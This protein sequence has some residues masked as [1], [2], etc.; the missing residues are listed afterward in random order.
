MMH[1][2]NFGNDKVSCAC[3]GTMMMGTRITK[4]DSYKI[5]NDFTENGGNFLDTSDNYSWWWGKGNS[6][7]DES[8]SILGKW[9]SERKNRSKIFLATKFGA[10]PVHPDK[11][12]DEKGG[13]IWDKANNDYEGASAK[14]VKAAIDGS[15]KRLKTDYI[16][17]YYLH[18]DDRSVPLEE[19]LSAL[20]DI[21]KEGKVRYIGCSNMRT[22]R[23]S[24]A[25]KISREKGYPLF[26]AIEEE[27]SYIR[28]NMEADRGITTH[29]DDELFDY[30]KSNPDMK[31]IAYSPV[32]KGIFASK[33]KR[34]KYY[35]WPNFNNG[36]SVER[37]KLIDRMSKE[38]GI[39]GSQLVLAWILHKRPEIIP[40]LGF[41][42]FSQ[43][44]E[45]LEAA[46]VKLSAEQ[47]DVLNKGK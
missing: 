21:V 31:L 24:I 9:M 11:I 29:A 47:M 43:Y 32:L 18:V 44:K 20:A 34:E 22:W 40:I 8:E 27:Y 7:G 4:D 6:A 41:S 15:L 3:L 19:T 17:L 45:N 36:E 13:I 30:L 33:E 12:R 39:T 10:R 5:L 37:I 26:S 14:A 23:L 35:D 28:P 1:K 2:V 46:N 16:D 25:R 38:I 42:R